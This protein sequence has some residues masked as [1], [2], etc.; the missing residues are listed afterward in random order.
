MSLAGCCWKMLSEQLACPVVACQ[1]S[2]SS[3]CGEAH[4]CLVVE[5]HVTA[6]SCAHRPLHGWS[7][8]VVVMSCMHVGEVAT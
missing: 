8:R 3:S 6:A 4:C 1:C 7:L 2:A 5:C